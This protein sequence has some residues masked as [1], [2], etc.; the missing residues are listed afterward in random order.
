MNTHTQRER[1]RSAH[2]GEA[3]K[4]DDAGTEV[5]AAATTFSINRG[6]S[7]QHQQWQ[8]CSAS[9]VATVF[10]ISS[11]NSVQH[12]QWQQCSASTVAT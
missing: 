2:A 5:V 6:N 4:A 11:G 10:S 9:A 1:E 7:V 3:H 8:Q 12:Q